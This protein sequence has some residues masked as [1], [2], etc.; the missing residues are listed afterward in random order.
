MASLYEQL[1]AAKGAPKAAAAPNF[2]QLR[3]APVSLRSAMR[4]YA[5]GG[6]VTNTA[7]DY[8]RAYD[9]FGGAGGVNDLRNQFL[10]MGLDENTIGSIF[11]KYYAPETSQPAPQTLTPPPPEEPRY[12][13]PPP[14]EPRYEEP[15]RP[16]AP[17]R[18]TPYRPERLDMPEIYPEDYAGPRTTGSTQT[19]QVGPRTSYRQEA[20]GTL[21]EIGYNGDPISGYTP[22]QLAMHNATTGVTPPEYRYVWNGEGYDKL[23][24]GPQIGYNPEPE[25]PRPDPQTRYEDP[26]KEQEAEE[27]RRKQEIEDLRREQ[28]SIARQR[29]AEEYYFRM[30][31][32]QSEEPRYEE[33][34]APQ[35]PYYPDMPMPETYIEPEVNFPTDP[36][37]YQPPVDYY[38]PSP[39]MD[40]T[41]DPGFAPMPTPIGI[42]KSLERG[43]DIGKLVQDLASRGQ[44]SDGLAA[45]IAKILASG[46]GG[47]LEKQRGLME[48]L[49]S[50]KGK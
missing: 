28:E 10:G 30:R 7:P 31:N 15:P 49:G 41:Q 26:R 18:E 21:T 20:D 4:K 37:F 17:D 39:P 36:G 47:S 27:G 50:I 43:G 24:N 48:L 9:A 14:P 8:S 25:M 23:P 46:G 13:P 22:E 38:N 1:M 29:E 19:Q 3:K 34:I 44:T 32:A 2:T 35:M 42:A 33:P 12:Q 45:L 16:I 5:A 11:S 6:D 40:F